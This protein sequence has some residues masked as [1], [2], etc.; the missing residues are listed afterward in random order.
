M[1]PTLRVVC[2]KV[3]T[4]TY[5]STMYTNST[6]VIILL[7]EV[8]TLLSIRYVYYWLTAVAHTEN[9]ATMDP[10]LIRTGLGWSSPYELC[11]IVRFRL[12]SRYLCTFLS[13]RHRY[14]DIDIDRVD[15][16][17]TAAVPTPARPGFFQRQAPLNFARP[18]DVNDC[19][20]LLIECR[21][22]RRLWIV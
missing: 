10:K 17:T 21:F 13:R 7:S 18:Y 3:T 5:D 4:T 6:M 19:V 14:V 22:G 16:D 9:R 15:I 12:Y 1:L 8:L 11:S 2:A 20:G